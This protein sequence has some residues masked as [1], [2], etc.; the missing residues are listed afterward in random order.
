MSNRTRTP[1]NTISAITIGGLELPAMSRDRA[2]LLTWGPSWGARDRAM[3]RAA[4]WGRRASV[5]LLDVGLLPV[6]AL[7]GRHTTHTPAT[8]PLIT[9]TNLLWISTAKLKVCIMGELL[10]SR[11]RFDPWRIIWAPRPHKGPWPCR[12]CPIKIILLHKVGPLDACW[13]SHL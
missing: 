11:N 4:K 7:V 5:L 13:N 10:D 2:M 8:P 6:L 9:S 3:R 1:R 12:P